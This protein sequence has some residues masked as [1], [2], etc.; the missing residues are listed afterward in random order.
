MSLTLA[1]GLLVS[2]YLTAERTGGLSCR[3]GWHMGT[4]A[5]AIT[6]ATSPAIDLS[7]ISLLSF[8][9]SLYSAFSVLRSLGERRTRAVRPSVYPSVRPSV[10]PVACTD[11]CYPTFLPQAFYI[12]LS[13]RPVRRIDREC[14]HRTL[15]HSELVESYDNVSV[16]MMKRICVKTC[17]QY[18]LRDDR[19]TLIDA[20]VNARI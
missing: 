4:M 14:I 1:N 7:A 16:S 10:F 11:V 15:V 17:Q 9:F 3:D 12:R 18:S 19:A 6:M 20:R 5:H 8:P 2:A 13:F